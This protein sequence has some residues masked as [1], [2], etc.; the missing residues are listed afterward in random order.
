VP[1]RV[2]E[3][4]PDRAAGGPADRDMAAAPRLNLH[5]DCFVGR[6]ASSLPDGV[7]QKYGSLLR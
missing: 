2:L 1:G 6:H 7:A 5:P 3:R 4:S